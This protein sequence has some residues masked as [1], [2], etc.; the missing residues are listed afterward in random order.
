MEVKNFNDWKQLFEAGTENRTRAGIHVA[1]IYRDLDNPN[2]VTVMS[3]V[4]NAEV[5]KAFVANLLP[6]LEKSGHVVGDAQ[7]MMLEKA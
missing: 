4:A 2:Q 6:S 3:D 7:F 5:A 1:N